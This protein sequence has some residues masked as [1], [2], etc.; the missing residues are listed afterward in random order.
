MAQL[1]NV[2]LPS[3]PPDEPGD[4]GPGAAS[5]SAA[6]TW[7]RERLE[8]TRP[9]VHDWLAVA[10]L[11]EPIASLEP[12]VELLVYSPEP[13]EAVVD[14]WSFT[15]HILREL[16][17]AVRVGHGRLVIAYVPA[18]MEVNEQSWELTR[19]RYAHDAPGWDRGRVVA[20]LHAALRATGVPI[21]D[22]TAPLREVERGLLASPYH[23]EGGHWNA[24]GHATAAR[25]L[26]EWL[27]PRDWLSR[28]GSPQS[29]GG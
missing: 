5:G 15:G 23:T 20:S 4:P 13:P 19:R 9:R 14:A 2:P 1:V 22:L 27:A 3:P 17:S 10:G 8:R 26:E 21:V 24:L 6:L 18:K 28:C 11:W 7:A 16:D 12:P 25:A 29:P